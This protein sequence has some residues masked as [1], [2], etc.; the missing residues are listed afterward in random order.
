MSKLYVISGPNGAGKTT[1]A[2]KFL[3][4]YGK[5]DEFVNADLIAQGLAPLKPE[6]AAFGAGRLVIKRIQELAKKRTDFAFETTLSGK[7]YLKFLKHLKKNGYE[8][9]FF[10]LW[11]PSADLALK[12]I[13]ERVAMGGHNVPKADVTRRFGKSLKN[14]FRLYWNLADKILILDNSSLRPEVVAMKSKSGLEIYNRSLYELIAQ[15][16]S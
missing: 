10:Y 8:I 2:R 15:G 11:I 7:S 9:L 1:F 16:A 14:L 4:H 3:P 5:C 12:R 13:K 6:K